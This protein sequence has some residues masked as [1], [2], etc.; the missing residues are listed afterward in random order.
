MLSHITQL[1]TMTFQAPF[2]S[3][4]NQNTAPGRYAQELPVALWLLNLNLKIFVQQSHHR[5]S[6]ASYGSIDFQLQ[7]CPHLNHCV[8]WSWAFGFAVEQH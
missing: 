7:R 4:C 2:P 3:G 8:E 1:L 5:R 6:C